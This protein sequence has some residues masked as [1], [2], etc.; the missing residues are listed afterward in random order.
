MRTRAQTFTYDTSGARSTRGDQDDLR[1]LT[2]HSVR[3]PEL[4][5]GQKD[6]SSINL[7]VHEAL[8]AAVAE[9]LRLERSDEEVTELDV[10][11]WAVVWP[12]VG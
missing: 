7:A 2:G 9:A 5:A 4:V 3:L 8:P 11:E 6:E 1:V 10:G 12:L